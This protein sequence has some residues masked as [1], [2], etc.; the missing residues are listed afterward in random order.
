MERIGTDRNRTR[1]GMDIT[2]RHGFFIAMCRIIEPRASWVRGRLCPH[3]V[4][5]AQASM[6][7]YRPGCAGVYAG[8]PSWVRG[9]LCP[10]A[11]LGAQAS[12]PAYRPGCAGVY[13]RM[14]SW[15]RGR[16]RPH[17]ETITDQNRTRM[18]TDRTDRHGF[19]DFEIRVH[20]SHPY[21]SVVKFREPS[22]SSGLARI[23]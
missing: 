23:L 10:H 5:G 12:M 3:T 2:D 18:G 9:R 16:P 19:F 4:L 7:A 20:P 14:P 15:V 8:I 1:M 21:Q 22:V 11:V 17:A 6:P 13:A